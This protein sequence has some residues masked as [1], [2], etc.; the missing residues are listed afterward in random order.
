MLLPCQTGT[1]TELGLARKT[2]DIPNLRHNAGG[3][4]RTDTGY[5]YQAS[6]PSH[7]R[8]QSEKDW[9]KP[10][11]QMAVQRLRQTASWFEANF[12]VRRTDLLWSNHCWFNRGEQNYY[13]IDTKEQ[14]YHG[15][16]KLIVQL[17][18]SYQGT[19]IVSKNIIRDGG[20]CRGLYLSMSYLPSAKKLRTLLKYTRNPDRICK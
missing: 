1:L 16:T 3:D 7:I 6:T 9:C 12:R 14:L 13:L 4:H 8:I 19:F 10:Y 5:G 11:C 20:I 2:V 17:L 15:F 18:F